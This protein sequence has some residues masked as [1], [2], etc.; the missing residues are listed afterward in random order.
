MK[1]I[2][3]IKDLSIS[4]LKEK[5]KTDLELIYK[6][7]WNN[8]SEGLMNDAKSLYESYIEN[9]NNRDKKY[10]KNAIDKQEEAI[11]V[12]IKMIT[13]FHYKFSI[14]RDNAQKEILH[15]YINI[16]QIHLS[17]LQYQCNQLIYRE[18]QRHN[19]FS[20]NVALWALVLAFFS[21]FTSIAF[22]YFDIKHNRILSNSQ[23]ECLF[24]SIKTLNEKMY[25]QNEKIEKYFLNQ[26]H[27]SIA[28][29][30]ITN[31]LK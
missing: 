1:M 16:L 7:G 14:E 21:G 27:D 17:R 26:K 22:T 23:I 28:S 2:E 5:N 8:I 10:L 3:A 13:A 25:Q 29:P 11:D 9:K 6:G 12:F 19:R 18:Q 20:R 30:K 4:F 31:K 15:D 24:D